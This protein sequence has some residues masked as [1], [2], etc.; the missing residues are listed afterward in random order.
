MECIDD[1]R[2]ALREP[3]RPRRLGEPRDRSVRPLP[4][5]AALVFRELQAA[6]LGVVAAH[7]YLD[8]GYPWVRVVFAATPA[9]APKQAVAAGRAIATALGGEA[10]VHVAS[11]QPQAASFV[12][13]RPATAASDPRP[14]PATRYAAP[15]AAIEA[16]WG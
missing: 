14:L 10:V 6:G 13:D 11:L 2:A 8:V 4:H 12:L 3:P 15:L 9:V 16:V 5:W 7:C 1:W